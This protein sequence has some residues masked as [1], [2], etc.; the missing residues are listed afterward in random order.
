MEVVERADI[1]QERQRVCIA[2][3][4]DMLAVIDGFARLPIGISGRS[5]PKT[6]AGF[7]DRYTSALT[8]QPYGRTQAGESGADDGNVELAPGTRVVHDCHS[9]CLSAIIA[10]VGRGTRAPAEKMS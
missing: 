2:A 7:E 6:A 4:Q 9:H 1:A 10:W 8:S 5:S 3:E